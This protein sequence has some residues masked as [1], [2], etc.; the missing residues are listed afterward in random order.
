[1]RGNNLC[2][3]WHKLLDTPEFDRWTCGNLSSPACTVFSHGDK[4][5]KGLTPGNSSDEYAYY[6]AMFLLL[7]TRD[8]C[9]SCWRCRSL[10]I[11]YWL[12]CYFSAEVSP[13]DKATF[14]EL[15][16]VCFRC[17]RLFTCLNK[18]PE[19]EFPKLQ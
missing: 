1:M 2:Q 8:W 16:Q 4:I 5:L 14:G 17:H 15:C 12:W 11:H 3:Y 6:V 19:N 13:T 7:D 9:C 10:S 18:L